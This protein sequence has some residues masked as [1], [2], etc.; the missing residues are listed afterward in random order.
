M[1]DD[2][3]CLNCKPKETL[4]TSEVQKLASGK[5]NGDTRGEFADSSE[6]VPEW[7]KK[8]GN[9]SPY[10]K[11]LT[12]DKAFSLSD[13]SKLEEV[14][15]ELKKGISLK[16]ELSTDASESWVYF[17]AA[18]PSKDPLT[19]SGPAEAY[20]GDINRGLKKTDKQGNVTF[21]L[22][23]PQPYRVA[24]KT[25]CRH[26]HYVTEN[27]ATGIWNPMKTFRVVCQIPLEDLDTVVKERAAFVIN[28]LPKEMYDREKIPKSLNLPRES[29]DK[30][31]EKAKRKRVMA[32]LNEHL[33]EYPIIK[34]HVDN[35]KLALEDV[36]IVVYCDNPKCKSSGRLIDHLYE[37]GVNNVLEFS[38]GVK[39]WMKERSFYEDSE[40]DEETEDSDEPDDTSDESDGTDEEYT[41]ITFEGVP[42]YMKAGSTDVY[43]DN[44][45]KVGKAKM[46]DGECIQIKWVSKNA[47]KEHLRER[48][49]ES[50]ESEDES[51]S[52]DKSESEPEPDPETIED[53]DTPEDEDEDEDEAVDTPEDEDE[54]EAVDTPEDEDTPEEEEEA[55]EEDED[56]PEAADTPEDEDKD[57]PV[58]KVYGY[59]DSELQKMKLPELREL[60]NSLGKRKAGS[61]SF[62][63]G[64]HG[65][66]KKDELI[67]LILGCQGKPTKVRSSYRFLDVYDLRK[68]K[69]SELKDIVK[70]MTEREPDTYKYVISK[71]R[72]GQLI[73][74]ILSCRGTPNKPQKG[75][76]DNTYYTTG[77]HVRA[78]NR[79]RW[80]YSF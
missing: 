32:F 21:V 67:G 80:G 12:C 79:F 40:T 70:M 49:G 27:K 71:W 1:S 50:Y 64:K 28:S 51:D 56:T 76:L 11:E 37:A 69:I 65:L 19:I 4:S 48:D 47:K 75:G 7:S 55:E 54:D 17:W 68:K 61:M 41:D 22:N 62:P 46:K 42:Y 30:L 44:L 63:I 33:E 16:M 52:D 45:D 73:G 25:Y 14:E 10:P 78:K 43:D 15:P 23:C 39:G 72:K 20:E 74:F 35:G 66:S 24:E 36:P 13:R 29:L 2:T 38:P 34:K 58:D 53:K 5:G 77:P 3:I 8:V 26:V 31:S 57:T 18:M 59:D 9:Y 60:V 6:E